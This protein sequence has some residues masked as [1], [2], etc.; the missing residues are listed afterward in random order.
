[1][2]TLPPQ[3][4][5]DKFKVKSS[6]NSE[7]LFSITNIYDKIQ[8]K[9]ELEDKIN[10]TKKKYIKDFKYYDFEKIDKNIYYI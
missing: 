5:S 3:A 8:I 4:C 7:F 9:A 2:V 6:N 10:L 1:M